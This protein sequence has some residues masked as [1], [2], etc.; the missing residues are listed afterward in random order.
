MTLETIWKEYRSSLRA[1]LYSKISNAA[2]IDDL[3]QEILIKTHQNLAKVRTEVSIKPWLFQIAN[4]TIIDFYRRNKIFTELN[5]EETVSET[6]WL[7]AQARDIKQEL[8]ACIEPFIQALNEQ[9]AALLTAI[10]INGE[11]QRQYAESLGLSYSTLKSRVQKARTQLRSLFDDCCQMELD[12]QG[13]LME[14]EPQ[15]R[16]SNRNSASNGSCN[17]CG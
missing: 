1:F 16:S 17:Q 2:D 11:S 7:K 4:H 14:Y 6:V 3:L 5:Q 9:D 15:K 13:N 10:D 12:T 8:S